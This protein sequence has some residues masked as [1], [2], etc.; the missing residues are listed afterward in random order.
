MQ[1]LFSL[2]TWV[3]FGFL[4]VLS[5]TL[6]FAMRE[7]V[8]TLDVY[9]DAFSEQLTWER[10]EKNHAR[11]KEWAW[12]GY[13][14]VPIIFAIKFMLITSCL[15]AGVFM[16]SISLKFRQLFSVVVVAELLFLLPTLIKVSWF[17]FVADSYTFQDVIYF[18]P[19]ALSGFVG[20]TKDTDKLLAYLLQVTNLFEVFYMLLLAFGLQYLTQKTYFNALIL[21]LK[22]YGLG[23]LLWITFV[24]FLIVS[25]S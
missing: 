2:N 12:L 24:S 22:S 11:R 3:V 10:I 6:S 21:T 17:V 1:R 14:L 7:L 5:I 4:C 23:L 25:F 13:V 18:S 19:W 16:D 15:Y 8:L 20:I 9:Y